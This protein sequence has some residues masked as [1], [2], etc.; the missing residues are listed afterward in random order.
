M[1]L[2]YNISSDI[3][4]SVYLALWL[5]YPLRNLNIDMKMGRNN[6]MSDNVA[7][8]TTSSCFE[9]SMTGCHSQSRHDS[10]CGMGLWF[11][12]SHLNVVLSSL[13][14]VPTL[15]H[16]YINVPNTQYLSPSYLSKVL[17]CRKPT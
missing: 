15:Q 8:N 12:F 14:E 3:M 4:Y 1:H 7:W 17:E 13:E 11:D 5:Q 6:P 9:A 16:F 10:R 2:E